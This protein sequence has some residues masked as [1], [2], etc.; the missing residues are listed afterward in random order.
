[1]F[2]RLKGTPERR[3]DKLVLI[4]VAA[5][6]RMSNPESHKEARC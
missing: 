1:L 3:Q 5:V 4:V 6:Q 2:R